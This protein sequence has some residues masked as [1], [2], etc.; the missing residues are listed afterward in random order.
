MK[1]KL[2]NTNESFVVE[3][4]EESVDIFALP[5]RDNTYTKTEIDG[6]LDA[7]SSLTLIPVD[8]L[9]TASADT[10]NGIYLVPRSGSSNQDNTRD[11]YVTVKTSDTEYIWEKIGS[12][13][14]D[15][16]EYYT[17]TE[18]DAMIPGVAVTPSEDEV[19]FTNPDGF[20]SASFKKGGAGVL[21]DI[22]GSQVAEL[23]NKA[24]VDRVGSGDFI[25]DTTGTLPAYSE[26]TDA[27][28]TGKTVKM[29]Y[30]DDGR[31]RYA[32][33]IGE[34]TMEQ[35]YA[36]YIGL[37]EGYSGSGVLRN[38]SFSFSYDD[39]GV[40][41]FSG[42]N[43]SEVTPSF[44][45]QVIEGGVG[46][47]MTLSKNNYS[48]GLQ[49]PTDNPAALRAYFRRTVA[50]TQQSKTFDLNT[51]QTTEVYNAD[52]TAADFNPVVTEFVKEGGVTYTKYRFYY[53]TS[54]LAAANA[55]KTF[56]FS[57][58]MADY[59][60][61]EWTNVSGF[62]DNG[63]KLSNGRTD[64]LGNVAILQQ[65]GRNS[66]ELIIRSYGDLSTRTAIL[67]LE[68]YGTKNA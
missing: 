65:L 19:T 7:L 56:N 16:S 25:V 23:P 39:N 22:S 20:N 46:T 4:G 48:F 34:Y 21:F 6:M 50:G 15:L 47:A 58:L 60:V 66:K 38:K 11:E 8:E 51:V 67:Q 17:K 59:T 31:I 27:L 14:I 18:V 62:T 28:L 40:M 54:V 35:Y 36:S 68:F 2:K 42:V 57:T 12:T 64:K 29:R 32:T 43:T 33:V 9:P 26:L 13:E 5:R 45:T 1:I 10:M 24:Y 30:I 41:T 55:T 49:Q 3:R 37:D 53:R 52:S 63:H 44:T 61:K